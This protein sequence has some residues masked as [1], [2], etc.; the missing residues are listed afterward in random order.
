MAACRRVYDSHHLQADCQ[1][2]DQLRNRTLGN[3]VWRPLPF[4]GYM[5]RENARSVPSAVAELLQRLI[6]P[7]RTVSVADSNDVLLDIRYFY[8][9]VAV[10]A[11]LPAV[12]LQ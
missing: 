12:A 1:E 11:R 4:L 2:P 9:R 6:E 7:L 10:L 5:S 8:R 3:R